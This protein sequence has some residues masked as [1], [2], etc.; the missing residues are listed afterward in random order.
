M[1]PNVEKQNEAFAADQ[2]LA[3]TAAQDR[4]EHAADQQII[5]AA[6]A[7]FFNRIGPFPT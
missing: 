4:L 5:C 3:D 7:D 2:P 1:E 6:T